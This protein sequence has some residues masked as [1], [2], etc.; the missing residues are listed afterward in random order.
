MFDFKRARPRCRI[1]IQYQDIHR[2]VFVS[3]SSVNISN[4]IGIDIYANRS[5]ITSG[6][7]GAIAELIFECIQPVIITVGRGRV[8]HNLSGFDDHCTMIRAVAD[9]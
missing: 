6:G 9:R 3:D 7:R 2:C 8:L 5:G 4:G 1:V